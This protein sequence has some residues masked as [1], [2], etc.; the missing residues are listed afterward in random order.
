LARFPLLVVAFFVTCAGGAVVSP[1]SADEWPLERQFVLVEPPPTVHGYPPP[2]SVAEDV[3]GALLVLLYWPVV[4][5]TEFGE[6][7]YPHTSLVRIAPDGSRAFV[8][9]FGEPERGSVDDQV[10]DEILPLP[11]SSILFTRRAELDRLRPNGSIVRV[12]GTGQYAQDASPSGDGGPATAA[13]IGTPHGLSR[14]P[15]GS[16]V[17]AE[18]SRIRRVASDGTITTIAGTGEWGYSGDGGAATAARL[19]S[20]NDVLPTRNGGF[21]IADT[22]NGRVRRVSADG[23]I[24]TIAGTE[25]NP[26][27][28]PVPFESTGDGGPA[29]AAALGLPGHLARL[30]DGSLLIGGEH[31]IRRVA[32]DGTISTIFHS[33]QAYGDRLGDFA[34]RYGEYIW[35]MEATREGGIAVIVSGS[36]LRALYLAP[37]RTRRTLVALRGARV[38]GRRVEM[39]VDATTRGLLRLKVR[40]GGKLVAQ[41]SRRVGS[42]RS[43]ISVGGPFAAADHRVSVTLRADRGGGYSD[44]IDLFTSET[45]PK[46]LVHTDVGERCQRLGRRR[47][48]CEVHVEE[49]EESGVPC[50]NS[51]AFRLF[52]SGLTFVRPYGPQCHPE[53]MRFDRTPDWTGPWRASPAR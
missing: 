22:F 42:G 34:G 37:R 3:N 28:S 50:L 1:A 43:T 19:A 9:P 8:P 10:D 47:I 48:D 39:T 14:F 24:S 26:F 35:A 21:W 49:N 29:T 13:D 46:R 36:R 33:K 40:R 7:E 38:S 2:S 17:F 45:L 27:T 53:P 6:T 16:I 30:A 51:I 25:Q 31:D 11:D 52:R 5:T 4:Q 15:D 18:R 32:P 20:P 12:A 23:V 41:A 44:R